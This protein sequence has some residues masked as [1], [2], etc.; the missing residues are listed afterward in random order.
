MIGSFITF[1]FRHVLEMFITENYSTIKKNQLLPDKNGTPDT[2]ASIIQSLKCLYD[3][4]PRLV[5]YKVIIKHKNY[6][7]YI[8]IYLIFLF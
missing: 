3:L 7:N 4:N 5:L 1:K 6:C 2:E 8:I